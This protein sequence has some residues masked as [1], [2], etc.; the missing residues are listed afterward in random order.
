MEESSMFSPGVGGSTFTAYG[1]L[2]GSGDRS[3]ESFPGPGDDDGSGGV[4]TCSVEIVNMC[5]YYARLAKNALPRPS[6]VPNRLEVKSDRRGVGS[7]GL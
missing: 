4:V 7:W 2:W 5:N 1:A 3:I 6:S